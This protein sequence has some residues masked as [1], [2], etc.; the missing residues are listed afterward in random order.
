MIASQ[1]MSKNVYT[2]KMWHFVT[3]TVPIQAY[4]VSL[5]E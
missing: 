5:D 3:L 4:R 2:L 1:I